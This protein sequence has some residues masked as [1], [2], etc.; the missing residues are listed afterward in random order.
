MRYLRSAIL[1][2]LA[3]MDIVLADNCVSG[4][5]E[6]DGNWYC[7][8]VEEIVYSNVGSAGSYNRVTNMA[9]DGVCSSI[10]Q[11]YSG[12]LSPFDEEVRFYLAFY[13]SLRLT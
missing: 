6:I 10:A 12:P 7:Q 2:A 11:S 4:S 13:R 5:Q 8:P 3:C 1:T 9:P